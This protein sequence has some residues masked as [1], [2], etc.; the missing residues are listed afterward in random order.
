MAPSATHC[1]DISA[2]SPHSPSQP[3]LHRNTKQTD[4]KFLIRRLDIT[5]SFTA[6]Q[7]ENAGM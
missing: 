1:A 5:I 7:L 4:W 6:R 3:N 2:I